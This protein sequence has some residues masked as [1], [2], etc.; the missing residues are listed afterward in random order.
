MLCQKG[1]DFVF[2]PEQPETEFQPDPDQKKAFNVNGG[3]RGQFKN[4]GLRFAY[5][6]FAV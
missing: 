5:I 6:F 4:P 1:N 3:K 2:T